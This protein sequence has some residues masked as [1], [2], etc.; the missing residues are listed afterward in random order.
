M[1]S[2]LRPPLRKSFAVVFSF[3]RFLCRCSL[4]WALAC[5]RQWG[6]VERRQRPE[7]TEWTE[8]PKGLPNGSMDQG[9]SPTAGPFRPP[10][11]PQGRRGGPQKVRCG[12]ATPLPPSPR[13]IR[14]APPPTRPISS[15]V[16]LHMAFIA[17]SFPYMCDKPLNVP[18]AYCA[19][20]YPPG[21]GQGAG[22]SWC[23]LWRRATLLC[24]PRASMVWLQCPYG[25]LAAPA[26]HGFHCP[27][28][29]LFASGAFRSTD[30]VWPFPLPECFGLS[31]CRRAAHVTVPPPR[32]VPLWGDRHLPPKP[33]APKAPRN[34]FPLL[35]VEL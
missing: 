11:P 19:A 23:R 17:F 4:G 7:G 14:M 22:A 8:I 18:Q 1:S 13:P 35:T 12:A 20:P 15:R 3:W 34:I 6:E 9:P 24:A 33:T 27:L 16:R 21:F 29:A 31:S 2:P 10:P 28:S 26:L 5:G 30:L 25:P 32:T